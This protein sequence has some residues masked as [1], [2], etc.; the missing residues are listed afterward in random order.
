MRV[1]I[2]NGVTGSGKDTFVKLCE[3]YAV[4]RN[5][6]SSDPAK[7]ALRLLGWNGEKDPLSRNLLAHLVELSRLHYD[8]GTKYLINAIKHSDTRTLDI[9][10]YHVREV[11][12]INRILK[13][14]SWCS[15]LFIDRDVEIPDGVDNSADLNARQDFPYDVVIENNG[16]LQELDEKAR[17]FVE[18]VMLWNL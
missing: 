4:C 17:K 14:C 8:G 9:L 15:T 12:Q 10:F 11:E 16:S 2:I 3:K 7:E 1:F 6:H 13:E 18:E 5:V